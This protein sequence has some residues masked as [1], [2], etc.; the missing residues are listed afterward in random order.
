MQGGVDGV[1]L[2]V[3][4]RW[5]DADPRRRWIGG[6]KHRGQ[7]GFCGGGGGGAKYFPENDDMIRCNEHGVIVCRARKQRFNTLGRLRTA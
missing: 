3:E 5:G 4:C 7:E 6:G 2:F 1:C